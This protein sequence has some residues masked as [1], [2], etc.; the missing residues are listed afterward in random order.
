MSER[1]C[2]VGSN[3]SREHLSGASRG[4]RG[5][6]AAWRLEAPMLTTPVVT[7]SWQS[8]ESGART[9]GTFAGRVGLSRIPRRGHTSC[10]I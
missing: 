1:M 10:W 9:Q 8:E 5:E 3:L 2:L 7:C 6:V 4:L